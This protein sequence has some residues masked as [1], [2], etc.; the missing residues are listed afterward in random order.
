MGTES[1][2][3]FRLG[4]W[5]QGT[6]LLMLLDL[7]STHSLLDAQVSKKFQGITSL[8]TSVSIKIVDVDIINCTHGISDCSW[9]M[10][11]YNFRNSFRYLPLVTMI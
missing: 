10:Q 9:W 5:I 4:D 2:S 8:Q 7:G 11:G 3:S 6:E 1:S